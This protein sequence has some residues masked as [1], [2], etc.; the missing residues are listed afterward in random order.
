M[1]ANRVTAMLLALGMMLAVPAASAQEMPTFEQPDLDVPCR[2][3][4]LMDQE[5]GAVLYEKQPDTPM[6]MASITKVMTLLLTFEALEEGRVKLEDTVPVSEHSYSMGGSQIWLEPG[7][8][9]TLEEM[10]KA[11]CVSSANDAAVAVAELLGGSEEAFV[12]Q[13]NRRA[14][15]LGLEHTHF[16]NACGLD[17][18]EHYSTARDVAS[19]SREMLNRHP[20]IVQYTTI[21]MDTVRE[22]RT[23]LLNTNKLLRRYQG[24]TGLKTGTTSGAGVCISASALRD[25]LGLIAVVLGSP[26]G[27]ERFQAAEALLDY[28]FAHFSSVAVPPPPG[29]PDALPVQ[30]GVQESVPLQYPAAGRVLLQKGEEG[31]L[32]VT[33]SLPEKLEAPVQRG[34][35]VGTVTAQAAGRVLLRQPILAG[36]TVEC[37]NLHTAIRKMLD[38]LLIL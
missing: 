8:E 7:E 22:G 9:L 25:G 20:G 3:A 29:A 11:I 21:W 12:Q 6:P 4:L 30:G 38:S 35:Q 34:Q 27:A 24:I 23:Q 36:Q 14:A 16:C 19:L 2:A 28:G 31:D 10:I 17:A 1:M 18:P 32:S 13:M 26:S 37:M 5:S 15:E 33:A